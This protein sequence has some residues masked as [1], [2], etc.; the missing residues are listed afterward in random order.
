M[1]AALLQ[2]NEGYFSENGYFGG[3]V[4]DL[5]VGGHLLRLIPFDQHDCNQV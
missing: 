2:N 1:F 3:D 5:G 4:E